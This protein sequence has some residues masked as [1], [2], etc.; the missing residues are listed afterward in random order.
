MNI[1]RGNGLKVDSTIPVFTDYYNGKTQELE[2][3]SVG[4][5]TDAPYTYRAESA[6]QTYA[7]VMLEL[8]TMLAGCIGYDCTGRLCVEPSQDDV[9]DSEKPVVYEI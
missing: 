6:G 1:D 8:N 4:Y 9:N 3:G 5:L 7:D 2:D